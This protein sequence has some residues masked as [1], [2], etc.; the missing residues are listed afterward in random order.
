MVGRYYIIPRL[1]RSPT[2]QGLCESACPCLAGSVWREEHWIT[3]T[4]H[5]LKG[6]CCWW[7]KELCQCINWNYHWTSQGSVAIGCGKAAWQSMVTDATKQHSKYAGWLSDKKS[8]G[9]V[10]LTV[11]N[12]GSWGKAEGRDGGLEVTS[13]HPGSCCTGFQGPSEGTVPPLCSWAQYLLLPHMDW[14]RKPRGWPHTFSKSFAGQY[15]G[16][17][18]SACP[19]LPTALEILPSSSSTYA[20]VIGFISIFMLGFWLTYFYFFLI[21]FIRIFSLCKLT[22][23]DCTLSWLF[24]LKFLDFL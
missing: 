6:E 4:N 16:A 9:G 20:E 13:G 12:E 17:P 1:G 24:Y 23:A 3:P 18:A 21:A 2:S 5:P 15:W 7:H 22:S 8:S 19:E 14:P 10:I 11:E